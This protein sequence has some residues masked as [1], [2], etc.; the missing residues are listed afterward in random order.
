MDLVFDW[1][2]REGGIVLSWWALVTLAGV[3][4]FPLCARLLGGLPDRGYTL[5]RAA[6]LLVVG[7]VFWLLAS[8][9]FVQNTSGNIVLAW[10][11]VLVGGIAVYV[12]SPGGPVDWRAWWRLNRAA[13]ITAE[14]VFL[15]LLFAWAL[16]RAYNPDM[17]STE[18][19]ME[20]MMLNSVIRS[21]TFPPH[22]AWMSGYSI[23]YYY[24]GY[25]IAAMLTKMSGVTGTI[26]FS[27]TNALLFA[28]TALTAF[29]AAYNL[30]RSRAVRADENRQQ[31]SYSAVLAGLLGTFF[32]AIMGNWQVPII[33]IPYLT[34]T[35]I[36]G[37]LEFW[38]TQS[39]DNSVF[40]PTNFDAID[41]FR[42]SRVLVD[43]QL[44]GDLEGIQPIDE[45]PQFS[46]LLA[47]NHPHVLALPFAVLALGLALNVVLAGH[48]P[49]PVEIVFY[50]LCLGG[51][52]F[53]NAWDGPIYMALLVG[54]ELLRRQIEK[55]RLTFSDWMEGFFL[56]VALVVLTLG[57]YLPFFI[58][59]RSQASGIL[60][61]VIWPTRFQQYFIMFGPFVLLLTPFLLLET[62]RA[63]SRM[64]WRLGLTLAGTLLG[65]L[66]AAV[67]LMLVIGSFNP[68]FQG[69][70]QG[71][72]SSFSDSGQAVLAIIARRLA[73]LALLTTLLLLAAVVLVL[74]RLFPRRSVEEY[75]TYAAPYSP[76]TAFALLLVGAAVLLTLLPDYVYLRDNFG[77]R[78]NTVFK[79]YY[80]AWV[81]FSIAS[82]YA[83]YTF[84]NDFSLV[85][86]SLAARYVYSV[87]LV[88]VIVLG[89]FYPVLGNNRRTIGEGAGVRAA[90]GNP[91]LTLDGGTN[92]LQSYDDYIVMM[93]L[94]QLVGNDDSVVAVEA[95]LGSYWASAEADTGRIGALTGI[96]TV[97]GWENHEGQW[98]G[99]TYGEIVGS[100]DPDIATLY[101]E[102]RWDVVQSIIERY[103]IEYI[104]Y[105]YAERVTF[106]PAGE[107]KFIEN[108][109]VVC[110]S[111]NSRVY[112]VRQSDLASG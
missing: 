91:A 90:D 34:Q 67:I 100:R 86:P 70:I 81:V 32:V 16:V 112:R 66:V 108:T 41:W 25:V 30:V 84:L 11:I 85:R 95:V 64:N 14:L 92:M 4:V 18:K 79:F 45:F 28:L 36:N 49:R 22:D 37:Y 98:R 69:I 101:N 77:T 7:F 106:E 87:A 15:V 5:A 75:E 42:A 71:V 107:Q 31:K 8:L 6:G 27:M 26:G 93:C 60:P 78:M 65:V 72:L 89:L 46:F 23:S 40:S 111:G 73:P 94:S 88:A 13:I 39:R 54:A 3:A 9:G 82:A 2:V 55:G 24:F 17:N 99:A 63:G 103:G 97:L 10:V 47:D 48:A 61:N 51:L 29:G 58:G 44:N 38:D 110:E 21:E 35:N 105:G 68:T 59:F 50:G 52:V 33:E 74:G 57:L 56:G 76:A 12:A 102:R 62:W 19:P 80:Q 43:R 109:D 83:V 1:L 20:M 96:N 104:L 53:L